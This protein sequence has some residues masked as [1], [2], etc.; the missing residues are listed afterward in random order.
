MAMRN[1]GVEM[2]QGDAIGL[3]ADW[4]PASFRAEGRAAALAG[5]A[6]SSCP[7]TGC[8]SLGRLHWLDGYLDGL[9]DPDCPPQWRG[10]RHLVDTLRQAVTTERLVRDAGS[11]VTLLAAGSAQ[12]SRQEDQ[13]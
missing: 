11:N 10:Y 4:L 12:R 2:G 7:Y 6:P 9:S 5:V 8:D 3:A 13:A 1:W